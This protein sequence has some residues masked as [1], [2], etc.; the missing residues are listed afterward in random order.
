MPESLVCDE[1]GSKATLYEELESAES[2]E[3]MP[4]EYNGWKITRILN[5]YHCAK[6]E[7]QS[8]WI[9]CSEIPFYRG[10]PDQGMAW[11]LNQRLRI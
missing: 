2:K 8:I 11:W 9:H 7:R 5:W 6:E 3:A 10:R 1:Q 4:K